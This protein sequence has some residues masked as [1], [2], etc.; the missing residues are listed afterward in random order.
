MKNQD[1]PFAFH[2]EA[3]ERFDE[4]SRQP[5][6]SVQALRPPQSNP[7]TPDLFPVIQIDPADII[8]APKFM[9]Q[10]DG[11]GDYAGVSW[12]SGDMLVGWSGGEFQTIK[13]LAE[14]M[15]QTAPLKGLVS[16][17]FVV[18]E[19]CTWLSE[20]LERQRSDLLSDYI[21]ARCENE[22]KTHDLWLPLF[23]TYSNREFRIGDVAFR[24]ISREIMD[25]WWSRIPPHVLEKPEQ[26]AA[27]RRR[28]S[29]LQGL[30]AACVSL[31]A[32]QRKAIELARAS[33]L[34]AIALLSIL[35]PSNLSSRLTCYSTLI[36]LEVFGGSCELV[37]DDG[38][39]GQISGSSHTQ[40][41]ADW[42]VHESADLR[43]G[44]LEA[45]DDL[46]RNRTTMEYR[47][48]LYDALILYSRQCHATE[49]SDK[50]VFTV[51]ALES[52]LLR[53]SN[54]PIQKNLG[55]RMAFVTGKNIDERKAIIKTVE[56]IYK[57]RS[58]FVHHG[59]TP[60]HLASLDTF[61]VYAW[62]TMVNMLGAVNHYRTKAALLG[63]LEDRKMA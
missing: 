15:A 21:A 1:A 22:I 28:R 46:A 42:Q 37:M 61:L 23:R 54:E 16:S 2:P 12:R 17:T 3:A 48:E 14:R 58:A 11:Y 50:L 59:Q 53:D 49:I 63:A 57:Y 10:V 40:R 8:S 18:T 56:E 36:G 20:T 27:L 19:V 5:L 13:E 41:N 38:K 62:T 29:R 9:F 6:Q 51:A 7:Q 60:R 44:L 35:S 32:E 52:I 47:R 30:L 31:R 24:T 4:V 34:N 25:E 26:M 43:P 45:L 33:A 55:E 39:V